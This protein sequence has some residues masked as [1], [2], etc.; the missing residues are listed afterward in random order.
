VDDQIA[1]QDGC[2][3]AVG[4]VAGEGDGSNADALGQT[5]SRTGEV[6]RDGAALHVIVV[7]GSAVV[8]DGSA[9]DDRTGEGD[10]ELVRSSG[11][12]ALIEPAE[13]QRRSTLDG[14]VAAGGE[15]VGR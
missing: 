7:R 13:I 10:G 14:D 11:A 1:R 3:A 5:S 12:D 2:S 8:G 4:V 6:R 15:C 9:I